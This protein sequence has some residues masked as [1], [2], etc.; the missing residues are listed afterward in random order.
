MTPPN[1]PRSN[2][3]DVVEFHRHFGIPLADRPEYPLTDQFFYR[4]KHMREELKELTDAWELGD[5]AGIA[6]A[7]IDLAYLTHGLAAMCGLPWDVLWADVHR[8]NMAKQRVTDDVK[9]HAF[10]IIKPDGWVP[11]QT[12]RIIADYTAQLE[13]FE[14]EAM[15]PAPTI[16]GSPVETVLDDTDEAA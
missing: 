2:H 5:L 11:P 12:E 15:N 7:C 8:A 10:N 13:L 16:G 1:I 3:D 9:P 14:Q 4:L 6:D